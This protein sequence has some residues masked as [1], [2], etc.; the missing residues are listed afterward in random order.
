MDETQS[1]VH[2]SS[3]DFETVLPLIEPEPGECKSTGLSKGQHIRSA[4]VEGDFETVLQLIESGEWKPRRLVRRGPKYA[5]L[6]FAAAH[7]R[8]DVVRIL[9]EKHGCDPNCKGANDRTPLHF[10]CYYGHIDIVQYLVTE[11]KCNAYAYAVIHSPLHYVFGIDMDKPPLCL[12]PLKNFKHVEIL[13]FLITSREFSRHKNIYGL[14]RML[15][16]VCRYGTLKDVK[17]FIET[18]FLASSHLHIARSLLHIANEIGRLDIVKYLVKNMYCDPANERNDDGNMTIAIHVACTYGLLDMLRYLVEEKH[19]DPEVCN[20]EGNTPLHLACMSGHL[21]IIKYLIVSRGCNPAVENEMFELPLHLACHKCSLEMV[22]LVCNFNPPLLIPVTA[23][24]TPFHIASSY[25]NLE[26]VKYLVNERRWFFSDCRDSKGYSP[27][28]YACQG[29]VTTYESGDDEYQK[30]FISFELVSFLVKVCGSDPMKSWFIETAIYTF[31]QMGNPIETAIRQ[32]NRKLLIALTCVSV[33]CV[34][35]SG[36]SP[37]HFA[38]KYRRI[39]IVRYLTDQRKCDHAIQNFYEELPLHIA[40]RWNSLEMAKLVGNCNVNTQ[41]IVGNTPLH[42][43]CKNKALETIRYL[44]KQRKCDHAIQNIHREL[45]LHIACQQVSLEMVELVSDCN[46]NIQSKNGDTPLHIA[47]KKGALEIIRYLVRKKG[48]SPPQHPEIYSNLSIHAACKSGNIALVRSIAT[49]DNVNYYHT[50]DEDYNTS[51]HYQEEFVYNTLLHRR[52]E[53]MYST[54]LNQREECMYG[55]PLHLACKVGNIELISFLVL[56]MHAD[57]NMVITTPTNK[58]LPLHIACQLNS[59]EMVQLVSGCEDVNYKDSF[60]DTPLHIACKHGT[61]N[62]VKYL[63]ENKGCDP[64]IPNNEKELPLHIACQRQSLEMAVLVSNCDLN[65]RRNSR[66]QRGN[67]LSEFQHRVKRGSQRNQSWSDERAL[68]D[69][70]LHIASR[71]GAVDIAKYLIESEKCDLTIAND[72]GELPLHCACQDSLEVV[73]LIADSCGQ[74]LVNRKTVHGVTPLHLACLYQKPEIVRFLIEEKESI[75]KVYDKSGLTPLHYAYGFCSYIRIKSDDSECTVAITK[76]LV[77]KCGCDPFEEGKNKSHVKDDQ[78]SPFA[79]AIVNGNLKLVKVLA[80]GSLDLNHLNS[81]GETVL[82]IACRHRQLNIVKFLVEDRCCNP[83]IQNFKGELALHIACERD[84]LDIIKLVSGCGINIRTITGETP[85]HIACKH[86]RV[87]I[88]QHLVQ[89]YSDSTILDSDGNLPL[90]IACERNSLALVKLVSNCD[91]NAKTKAGNT[92]LHTALCQYYRRTC[93]PRAMSYVLKTQHIIEYLVDEKKCNSTLPDS[94]N[95]IPI[96]EACR[97]SELCLI[98]LLADTESV[99]CKSQ[100]DNM[101][102]PLHVACLYGN[103]EITKF[104]VE[105]YECGVNIQNKDGDTPLH[106]VCKRSVHTET[107]VKIIQCLVNRATECDTSIVNNEGQ[108]PLHIACA[109][110]HTISV[111]VLELLSRSDPKVYNSKNQLGD[112]PLHIACRRTSQKVA[113]YLIKRMNCNANIQNDKQQLPLHIACK[114]PRFFSDVIEQLSCQCDLNCTEKS[115][116]TP[117]HIVCRNG[118]LETVLKL[119]SIAH[120]HA[121]IQNNYGELPLHLACLHSLEMVRLVSAHTSHCPNITTSCGDTLLHIAC[122]HGNYHTVKHLVENMQCD[123]SI[124]NSEGLLPLHF[125]CCRGSVEMAELV[126]NCIPDIQ[127]IADDGTITCPSE[128]D[129]D[130]YMQIMPPILYTRTCAKIRCGDTPL[131]VACRSGNLKLVKFLIEQKHSNANIQNNDGELPLHIAC[132]ATFQDSLEIVKL[133]SQCDPNIQTKCGYSPL[134][135]AVDHSH[136]SRAENYC[137]VETVRYLIAEKHCDSSVRSNQNELP[138]HLACHGGC[139]EIVDLVSGVDDV[140]LQTLSG[141]TPLH[142]ACM[143]PSLHNAI[144]IVEYL[145]EVK[146]SDRN[147]SNND[148]DLPLHIACRRKSPAIV[149][150][151]NAG[152]ISVNK[153][154]AAGN[155]PLH[156]VCIHIKQTS[157]IEE[158]H[159]YRSSQHSSTEDTGYSMQIVKY[160]ITEKSNPSACNKQG[161]LPLHLACRNGCFEIVKLVSR[162]DNINSQTLSGNSPLHEAC[163]VSDS[164]VISIVKYL[165]EVMQCDESICNNERELPLHIACR[166]KSLEMVKLVS[167]CK[168]NLKTKRGNTP[169]HEACIPT[170]EFNSRSPFYKA[171]LKELLKFLIEMGCDPSCWNDAGRTPLHYLCESDADTAAIEY[172]LST[173]K[174]ELSVVDNKGQTPIMLTTNLEVTKLLLKHGAD[175]TPLYEMHHN[176]FKT[177]TPPPTPLK[178]LVV[179]NASMGKTTLIESLKNEVNQIFQDDPKPHTAGI[180]PNDFESKIYGSVTLYDFAGQHEYYASHEAVVH[181]IIKSSSPVIVLLINVTESKSDIKKSILYWLSFIENRCTV[182]RVKSHLIVIGSHTDCFKESDGSNPQDKLDIIITALQSRLQKSPLRLVASVAMDC[183]QSHSPGIITLRHH[184]QESSTKLRDAA[185]MKF[186]S[187]CFCVFLQDKLQHFEAL[188]LEQITNI[189]LCHASHISTRHARMSLT[190]SNKPEALLPTDTEEILRICEELNDKGHFIF[191]R[192]HSKPQM[193]WV[194]LNKEKLLG[195]VNGTV[196][197]PHSFEQHRSLASNTGVVP[198]HKITTQFS[199]HDPNMIVEFLSYM[200]FCQ[201][202]HDQEVLD[203]LTSDDRSTRPWSSLERYFFFPSLVSIETPNGVWQNDSRY[204]YQWGWILHCTETDQFFTPYFLQVLILRLTFSFA[205]KPSNYPTDDE[206][207]A[208]KRVCSVWKKG[209]CWTCTGGVEAIVELLEQNQVVAVMVRSYRKAVNE[210]KCIHLRSQIMKKVFQAKESFCPNVSTAESFIHPKDLQY[211]L[212]RITETSLFALPTVA[213]A[214]VES[215]PC[216]VSDNGEMLDIEELISFDPYSDVDESILETLFDQQNREKQVT[217]EFLYDFSSSIVE[218]T[219]QHETLEF[220]KKLFIKIFKLRKVMLKRGSRDADEVHKVLAIFQA[221]Q[222]NSA[223]TYQCLR[224]MLDE[225]SVFCGRNPLVSAQSTVHVLHW[226][227]GEGRVGT[228]MP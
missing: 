93:Y 52:E 112:T 151:V 137:R 153:R 82:H 36:N 87:A 187:H 109:N 104:L 111:K 119:L 79:K 117:L 28:H 43:A 12:Q 203:I 178:V 170:S 20:N 66:G 192:N 168:P 8:L 163:M 227:F 103:L 209:I 180:I 217:D 125:A 198:F 136:N 23:K 49:S 145:T 76:Y 172:I 1:S 58:V 26:I 165:A 63:L 15:H 212:P 197:A 91:V 204:G 177:K 78:I 55:S 191:L 85:L 189:I 5:V 175:A 35:R 169:F 92:P 127:T 195:T 124:R 155:T 21:E 4:C 115:G 190:D 38:C 222:H 70:P 126:S 141:N 105:I 205:L 7:G 34:D 143:V 200:E 62:I 75:V 40:C 224:E 33:N 84:C 110:S 129:G 69:T 215:E 142:E 150:L 14:S 118:S 80:S 158:L 61:S 159:S 121:N 201:E 167:R 97:N 202:I 122:R 83:S 86:N 208:I 174:P 154:N 173:Q 45:P 32:S 90:H 186:T 89:N 219:D 22:K 181:S 6:H 193:S 65:C 223:G 199:E 194:I 44:T 96:H 17:F 114:K 99:N 135:L 206:M 207:P 171:C 57:L 9:V 213:R 228:Y 147:V 24:K 72:R 98:K 210:I 157:S 102:T 18:K 11:Q 221:W 25:G 138:L 140:N 218:N 166:R 59:F 41:D 46:V 113:S 162:V 73:R 161:E 160:L 182:L 53:Y 131:H 3:V 148:G 51:L 133:V 144:P 152:S 42:I 214:I 77:T 71:L 68:G 39:E 2:S 107:G 196:F 116:D 132:G 106:L 74:N 30:V 184:L 185:V 60:G 95:K 48:C 216:A 108:L 29:E 13:K 101:N 27:L 88:V 149:K 211:P 31:H 134:H 123:C 67:I 120:C 128:D 47:C 183:R 220:K 188:R 56:E 146:K 164:D 37:L 81:N 226:I 94:Y 176:F 156:E 50:F 10:A 130:D 100:R 139:L 64:T 19:V 16:V 179:G 54:P 225:Y